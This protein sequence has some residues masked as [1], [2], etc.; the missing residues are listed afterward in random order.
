[1][2]IKTTPIK[3]TVDYMPKEAQIRQELINKILETY[4]K[5]GFLLVKTPILENIELL[6]LG[7]SGDNQKLMFKTI[8]R[9]E[10]LDLSKPDLCEKDIVEEGL[11]YDL[12][13]PLSR[14]YAGNKEKL[15]LPFKAAQIDESFR[16][17]KPQKGRDR[18]FT[19]CDIDLWG[20]PTNLAEIEII[21]TI[22]QAY[23]NVGLNDLIV[24]VSDRNVLNSLIVF[25]G[26]DPKDATSICITIDKLDKIQLEG[27]KNELIAKE[28]D[29]NKIEILISA[30]TNILVN[31]ISALSSYGVEESCI[32]N[33]T[34]IIETCKKFIPS[35]YDIVF[36]ISIVRGQG[37]YT[38]TVFETF[39]K[40]GSYKGALGGGGRYDKMLEK[41]LGQNVPAVGYGL[42]FVPTM[43]LVVENNLASL[44][45][46]K[47]IAL[48]FD[49]DMNKLDVLTKKEQLMKDYDVSIFPYPK[50]FKDFTN[51]L[52]NAGFNGIYKMFN[53]SL[54]LFEN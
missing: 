7:D 49:K 39:C 46:R 19:Q 25:A 6:T 53:E 21:T 50:N 9:G 35:D 30:L 40:T 28:F 26:F 2:K 38:G 45:M 20:E 54:I 36:D 44:N 16:A 42:G 27:V 14:F 29:S 4:T 47:K 18:Q 52:Q 22:C 5:N 23:K 10:K 24:K 33:L 37:Y 15:P 13:V 31:G 12:T 48:L 3:G 51:K 41:Y 32:E 1:M 8:K 17:E 34:N 11:R 43:M